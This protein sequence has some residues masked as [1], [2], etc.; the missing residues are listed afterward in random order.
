L[1]AS[2]RYVAGSSDQISEEELRRVVRE[3]LEEGEKLMPTLVEQWLEQGREEGREEGLEQGLER[4]REAALSVLRRF[5]AQRFGVALDHFDPAFH[6]LDLSAITT[7]SEAA[8]EAE[9]LAEFEARLA[10]L[11]A[12]SKGPAQ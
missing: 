1:A 4:G 11:Q 12:Q 7:L 9:T 3:A 10:E 8:F 6:N 5:L 2:L